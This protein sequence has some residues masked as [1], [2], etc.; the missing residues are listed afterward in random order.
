[1][2]DKTEMHTVGFFFFFFFFFFFVGGGGG[3]I[4]SN[5]SAIWFIA[6]TIY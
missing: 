3:G 2:P 5:I 6:S 4:R 1:M